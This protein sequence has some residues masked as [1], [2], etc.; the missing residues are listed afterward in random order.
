MTTELQTTL[1]A[2]IEL[3][4]PDLKTEQLNYVLNYG[5]YLQKTEVDTG[6]LKY[7]VHEHVA[8]TGIGFTCIFKSS[9]NGKDY[10]KV[11]GFGVVNGSHD[12]QEVIENLT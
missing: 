11:Y 5:K 7:E 10:I 1:N 8:P 2:E 9:E 6:T 4:L 12:W 3:L